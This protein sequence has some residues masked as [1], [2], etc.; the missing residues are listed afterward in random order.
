M[1]KEKEVQLFNEH[2]KLYVVELR[3]FGIH[4][5]FTI[6]VLSGGWVHIQIG[7]IGFNLWW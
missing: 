6:T 1:W 3:D 4:F 7:W 2:L 5:G